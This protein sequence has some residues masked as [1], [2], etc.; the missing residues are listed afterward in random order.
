MFSG[1]G[2]IMYYRRRISTII[3]LSVHDS[4]P[5]SYKMK[6]HE[7]AFSA[8]KKFFRKTKKRVLG[9]GSFHLNPRSYRTSIVPVLR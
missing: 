8:H 9:P 2:K 1:V 4:I 3:H 7:K 6:V 5:I